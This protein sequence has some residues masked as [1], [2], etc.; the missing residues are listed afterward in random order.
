MPQH[1]QPSSQRHSDGLR[2]HRP[3][4][5][6]LNC[7]SGQLSVKQPRLGEAVPEHRHPAAN[8]SENS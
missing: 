2:N 3:T 5:S 4:S 1:D 6:R 7:W 8:R